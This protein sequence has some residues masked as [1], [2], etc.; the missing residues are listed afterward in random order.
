MQLK[1]SLG[2][3][4]RCLEWPRLDLSGVDHLPPA[5]SP[6]FSFDKMGHD[7]VPWSGLWRR[8][9]CLLDCWSGEEPEPGVCARRSKPDER[10]VGLAASRRSGFL[11]Q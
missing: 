4:S 6:R 11:L 5:R 7:W 2:W 3:R 1:L 10:G 9:V 8:R